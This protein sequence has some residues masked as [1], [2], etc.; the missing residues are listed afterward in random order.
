MR[1]RHA[2][3]PANRRQVEFMAG[4]GMPEAGIARMVGMDA[5]TLRTHYSEALE[6]GEFKANTKGRRE[7]LLQGDRR[8]REAVTAAI[9]LLKARAGWRETSVHE[10]TRKNAGPIIVERRK[11]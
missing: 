2:P 11:F 1:R 10:L 8:G 6:G 9:F 4:F 7:P 5:P 3:D